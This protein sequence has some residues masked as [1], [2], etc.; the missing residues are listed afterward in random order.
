MFGPRGYFGASDEILRRRNSEGAPL[1]TRRGPGMATPYPVLDVAG[2]GDTDAE[3]GDAAAAAASGEPPAAAPCP[4]AGHPHDA[5]KALAPIDA[6]QSAEPS[7]SAP[8]GV[9]VA[10][11]ARSLGAPAGSSAGAALVGR[12]E[13]TVVHHAPWRRW[14]VL[15][16]ASVGVLLAS[17][18]TSALIIGASSVRRRT[19]GRRAAGLRGGC[20]PRRAAARGRGLRRLGWWG[21]TGPP[22]P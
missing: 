16:V 5:A 10:P 19:S 4:G 11:S 22:P 18:S 17:I 1:E 6:E 21:S 15:A 8:G 13:A 7:A 20:A 14:A 3:L 9:L 2:S 12:A